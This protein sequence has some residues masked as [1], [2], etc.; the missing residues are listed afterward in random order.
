M[1]SKISR[2]R[3]AAC[4]KVCSSRPML[5]KTCAGKQAIMYAARKTRTLTLLVPIGLCKPSI[6]PVVIARRWIRSTQAFDREMVDSERKERI[7]SSKLQIHKSGVYC[8]I[9]KTA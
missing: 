4:S 3:R 6:L 7:R 2:R 1:V 5:S 9:K 8:I